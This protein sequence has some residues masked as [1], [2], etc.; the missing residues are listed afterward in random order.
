MINTCFEE[1][2]SAATNLTTS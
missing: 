1:L 2:S